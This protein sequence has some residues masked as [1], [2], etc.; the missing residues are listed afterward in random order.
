MCIRD[1]IYTAQPGNPE[2]RSLGLDDAFLASVSKTG[3][4]AVRYQR[5]AGPGFTLAR[6]PMGGGAPRDV[7]EHVETADWGPDGN[8][9]AVI[10]N[11]A[12]RFRLEYP[13]GKV[14]YEATYLT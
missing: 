1:S 4:L 8:N 5:G 12:G 2:S 9:L 10:R 3:E 7:A 14:L 6:M 11:E 13:I